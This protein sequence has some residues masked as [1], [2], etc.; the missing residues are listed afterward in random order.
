MKLYTA[1]GREQEKN[2]LYPKCNNIVSLQ[3][4]LQAARVDHIAPRMKDFRRGNGNFISADAVQLDLDNTHSEDPEDWRSID[5]VS[6]AFPDVQFYYV[7]SRNHMKQKK[8]VLKSG[9]VRHYEPREKDHLYFPLSHPITDYTE[10]ESLMLKTAGLF[11]FLDLSA[12]K[13]AQPFFGVEKPE[14]GAVEGSLYLDQFIAEQ[15]PE[16]IRQTIEDF[17]VKF[18]QT[19]EERKAKSR[20][21]NYLGIKEDTSPRS[22]DTATNIP[23]DLSW[24]KTAD[25]QRSLN[26]FLEWAESCG[27]QIG[28]HYEFST[29][30]HPDA[31]A[32]CV[33]CPWEDEHS[34]EGPENEAVVLIELS[35]QL[36]FI[37]RH[38]C[39]AGKTWKDYR[40][41]YEEKFK[42]R[43]GYKPGPD[44]EDIPEPKHALIPSEFS[45]VAQAELFAAEYGQELRYSKATGFLWYSGNVWKESE[46]KARRLAQLLTKR[47][48][49]EVRKMLWEARKRADAIAESNGKESVEAFSGDVSIKRAED[50]A[51]EIRKKVIARRASTKISATLAEAAPLLEVDVR[52]LD[53]DGFL[54]NTPGGTVDLRTGEIRDHDPS[55]YCTKITGVA[56]GT[57]GAELFEEFLDQIT[58]DDTDLK[59]YLQEIGGELAVGEVKREEVFIANGGGGNGKSTFFNLLFRTFGDYAGLLSSDVLITSSRKNKSPELAELRGKRMILA[60]ELDEGQR[61]DTAMIKKIASTDPIRAEKKYRDPFDFIPSHSIIL[62]T[63]FLPKVGAR[64]SGTWDRLRVIPFNARFRNTATEI[65]DYGSVLFEKCGG[66]VLSWIIDGARR[67]IANDF[68][69]EQPGC[70]KEAIEGY[71]NENDWLSAFLE[72]RCCIGF[73]YQEAGGE[74]YRNYRSYCD[75]MGDFPR[76]AAELKKALESVGI[77]YKKT[78]EGAVYRGIRLKDWTEIEADKSRMKRQA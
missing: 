64:D 21:F 77:K 55:D 2:T 23:E 6:E 44:P 31:I 33:S 4:L 76:S 19:D 28:T 10:Y 78:K 14:G 30:D 8:K 35:G 11:P 67:Y 16:T 24:I 41:Y 62:Y 74:L 36:G 66:A 26:W 43:I 38:N 73:Q 71:R 70:V 18:N 17:F 46:L 1:N 53:R 65:K 58:C 15:D 56:P 12:A 42:E 25:Q 68:R 75:S 54:L 49:K 13:P 57:E 69:I 34:M 37:C 29:K 40:S 50:E 48:L 22:A 3:D 47:Q 32:I 9:E 7:R 72:E 52:E 5:D 61:L 27:V 45:D 39:H 20:L 59:R 51:K 60:A 63:N